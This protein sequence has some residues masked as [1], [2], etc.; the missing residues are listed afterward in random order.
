MNFNMAAPAR[1]I[2]AI[3]A[4]GLFAVSC[5]SVQKSSGTTV[6]PTRHAGVYGASSEALREADALLR[7]NGYS[8]G[9]NVSY[10]ETNRVEIGPS[11]ARTTIHEQ[12]FA[13]PDTSY[14]KLDN[15]A[16][17]AVSKP[18]ILAAA[19]QNGG[20]EEEEKAYRHTISGMT[21]PKT[22]LILAIFSGDTITVYPFALTQIQLF[23]EDGSDTACH[24][25]GLNGAAAFTVY[26]S[27]WP[28]VS[29]DNHFAGAMG[30][31]AKV[32]PVTAEMPVIMPGDD[33]DDEEEQNEGPAFPSSIEGPTKAAAFKVEPSSSKAVFKTVLWLNK[34]GDW[35]VKGRLTFPIIENALDL[36]AVLTEALAHSSYEDRL[37]EVDRHINTGGLT[38]VRY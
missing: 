37:A 29:L 13:A 9:L 16:S 17:S 11:L 18:V 14:S 8:R 19:T 1:R 33:E 25:L 10:A 20:W 15:F 28:E 7:A 30:D 22:E 34:T 26:A 3:F 38:Q 6:A 24:Y 23:A 4:L 2:T 21:C 27:R 35:H 31:I 36:G 12:S 32:M 5:A